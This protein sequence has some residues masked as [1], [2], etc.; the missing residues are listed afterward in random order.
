MHYQVLNPLSATLCCS[1]KCGTDC[2][3][4]ASMQLCFPSITDVGSS[5]LPYNHECS[6]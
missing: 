4:I 3:S 2:R 5:I 1:S 6:L